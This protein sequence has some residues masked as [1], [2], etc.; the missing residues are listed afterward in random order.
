MEAEDNET[1]FP[2]HITVTTYS[3]WPY[4]SY[5]KEDD[6]WVGRGY[7]FELLKLLQ[8]KLNFTYTI[9]PP[10]IDVIG[11]DNSGMLQQLFRKEVDVAVA[12]IPALSEF[13]SWCNFSVPLEEMDTTFLLKR[14][15][16]S[17]TGSDLLA[18]FSNKVWIL[19][20]LSV[21]LVAPTTYIM[22]LLR[23]QFATDDRAKKFTL[24]NCLWFVYG[25][26]LKQG[27]TTAPIGDSTRIIFATWWIFITILTSFYTANLTAFLTLSKF[28]LDI[29]S[30][31]DLIR[32]GYSWF[33]IEGKSVQ[34]LMKYDYGD[35]KILR[36]YSNKYGFRSYDYNMSYQST[37]ALTKLGK[38]FIT[39][40]PFAQLAI[41]EDYRSKTLDGVKEENKCTYVI[42]EAN[43]LP[44]SRSFA[45]PADSPI[46]KHFDYELTN[47]VEGGLIKHLIS[48]KLP[49]AKYCP[50]TLD[51]KERRLKVSDLWLTYRVVFCG[52]GV[53][54]IVFFLELLTRIMRKMAKYHEN[55]R[56]VRQSAAATAD[57]SKASWDGGGIVNNN[58]NNNITQSIEKSVWMRTPPPLYQQHLSVDYPKSPMKTYTINGRDYYVMKND[59]GD[60]RLVPTGRTPSAYLFQYMH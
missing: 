38:V 49:L 18:P 36:Q 39:D 34:T 1:Q 33:V 29:N 6:E 4:S 14:P 52:M 9:V 25:A 59:H 47:A 2:A 51:S 45:F 20:L 15:Q 16:T 32:Y 44:K 10:K 28:T 5:G 27:T 37:L 54:G 7:A 8:E 26:L 31:D 23:M 57:R 22:I 58:D 53:A 40:R 12:F 55:R 35:A 41:F 24:F 43:V 48:E 42:S 50:L 13:R 17:S 56:K 21:L 46:K 60:R 3:D 30:I 19:I 11:D